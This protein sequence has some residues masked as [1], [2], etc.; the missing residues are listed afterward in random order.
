MEE[1][2]VYGGKSLYRTIYKMCTQKTPHDYSQ[3]LYDKYLEAFEEYI[4]STVLP[5][6]KEK[7][8]EFMLRELVRRW[9]NHK[10]MVRWLSRFFPNLDRYFIATRALPTV[11]EVGLACFHDLVYPEVKANAR[12]SVITLINKEREAEQIDTELL[13][14]VI[15]IFVEIGMG[16]KK[17]YEEDFEAQMHQDSVAYY[18]RKASSWFSNYSCPEYMLKVEECLKSERDRVSHYLLTSTE[19][20]LVEKVQHML[21]VVYQPQQLEKD[22][23]GCCDLLRDDYKLEDAAESHTTTNRRTS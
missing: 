9:A 17:L 15:D 22:Q 1:M 23:S 3:Q 21:V 4:T 10:V 5:S 18:S 13:K 19:Q 12:D 16:D 8:D 7:H 6:L 14:N 11:N 2:E 20:K